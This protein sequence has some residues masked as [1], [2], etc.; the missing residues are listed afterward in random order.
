MNNLW[1]RQ[2]S[3]QAL[4][5]GVESVSSWTNCGIIL[6][7]LSCSKCLKFLWWW[8]A[9]PWYLE[10]MLH[11]YMV[12]ISFLFFSF[13]SPCVCLLEGVCLCVLTLPLSLLEQPVCIW[14]LEMSIN[15]PVFP[16]LGPAVI[17]FCLLWSKVK[18]LLLPQDYRVFWSATVILV[19]IDLCV[20]RAT[21][22]SPFLKWL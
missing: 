20:L 22:L 19:I 3:C 17:D 14:V 11:C 10:Y 21:N 12:F 15:F 1:N 6:V 4:S 16:Y 2:F 9:F 18:S 5:R 13:S 7:F 8:A